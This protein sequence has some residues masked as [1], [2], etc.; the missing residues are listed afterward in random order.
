MPSGVTVGLIP[1]T[2]SPRHVDT[3]SAAWLL[4]PLV[5]IQGRMDEH[6][7]RETMAWATWWVMD[8][9]CVLAVGNSL[10]QKPG[11]LGVGVMP[12][13]LG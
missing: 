10:G 6:S 12:L 7:E 4:V 3:N 11:L 5:L 1:Q 13:P 9:R 2:A 8:K